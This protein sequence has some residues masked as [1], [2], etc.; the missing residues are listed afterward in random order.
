MKITIIT[1]ITIIIILMTDPWQLDTR[2]GILIESHAPARVDALQRSDRSSREDRATTV[3]SHGVGA[4]EGDICKCAVAD[5]MSKGEKHGSIN[6]SIFDSMHVVQREPPV[7]FD[8]MHIGEVRVHCGSHLS[9]RVDQTFHVP[10]TT[11]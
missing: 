10:N 9:A 6:W 4:G 1:A 3:K 2:G 5:N 11:R 8:S 7:D